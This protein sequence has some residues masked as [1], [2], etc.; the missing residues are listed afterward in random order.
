MNPLYAGV[1]VSALMLLLG[2][3]VQYGMYSFFMG[4]MKGAQDAL[5]GQLT[6]V[7]GQLAG[8]QGAMQALQ[9]HRAEL[10]IRMGQVERNA[11]GIV[12]LRGV[13]DQHLGVYGV[14]HAET[15]RRV[16][17]LER[18][19]EGQNR[20]LQNLMSRRASNTPIPGLMEIGSD[21]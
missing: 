12:A 17:K 11:D 7:I 15:I 2:A 10:D 16:E 3:L 21:G 8:F 19:F 20:Q 1:V 6:A 4:K 13:V 18:G 9:T 14:H 5:T